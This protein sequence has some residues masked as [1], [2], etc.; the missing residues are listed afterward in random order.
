MTGAG[1]RV[2]STLAVR[3]AIDALAASKDNPLAGMDVDFAPTAVLLKR[4]AE[5]EGADVAILTADGVDRLVGEG[6]L[7][8]GSR[9]DLVLSPI[10]LAVRSGA[11]H[12]RIDTLEAFVATLRA[13]PSL[14]YSRAGASG[15]FFADLIERLGLADDMAKKATVIPSGFT[16][17]IVARGDADLAIQQVSELLVIPGIEVVGR[18]PEG[19]QQ[20]STFSA[21]LFAASA[22]QAE[23]RALI[24]ALASPALADIYEAS[25]LVPV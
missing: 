5:G 1:L 2:M 20:I 13:A 23:A 24:E 11:L 14:V 22:R 19:A 6:V 25:G 15:I 9:R 4:I 12:P 17:E 3:G 8:K 21:G 16:A 18:L 10:G 7:A